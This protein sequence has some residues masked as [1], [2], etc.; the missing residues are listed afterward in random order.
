MLNSLRSFV[1]LGFCL[2]SFL[3]DAQEQING[4]FPFQTDPSKDYSI[5][6]PSG[7]EEGKEIAAFL[8]LHPWNTQNWDGRRWCEEI[9][10]FAEANQVILI[11]PDGGADGQID[12]PIDTAFTTVMIDSA[13]T[14]YTI[15]PDSLYA[16]GFSWGGKTTYTYGLNNVNKFAGFMP[17]GAATSVSDINGISDQ[18]FEKPF[19]L[20]HGGNDTPNTRFYPMIERLE[21]EGAF[22]ESLLM[23]GVGHTIWFPN[24]VEI[25]TDAYIWLKENSASIVD[26]QDELLEADNQILVKENYTVDMPLIFTDHISGPISIYSL[27]GRLLDTSRN[28]EINAPSHAGVYVVTIGTLS[29]QFIVSK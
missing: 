6:L 4:S 29:Q 8:A 28:N 17:I 23:P 21:E 27:D 2:L 18:A 20:V 15:A 1:I 3:S 12:D 19:Y 7:Y 13:M 14:W 9:S 5:Y 11:C 16:M 25:L 24:Q 22:V 10:D 26:V